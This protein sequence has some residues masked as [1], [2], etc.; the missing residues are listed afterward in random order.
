MGHAARSARGGSILV[1]LVFGVVLSACGSAATL[2]TVPAAEAATV[3][4]TE[5]GV[6]LLDIRTPEEFSDGRIAGS[7]NIDFYAA[8]FSNR[9]GSLDRE[10]TYVVY[11]RSGNR[12]DSAMDIFA[13]LGFKSVYEVDGGILGWVGAGLPVTG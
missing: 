1:A 13:D 12:S 7:I 3:L 10:T 11:C 5:P 8:D 9:L 6:V 4:D 2:E